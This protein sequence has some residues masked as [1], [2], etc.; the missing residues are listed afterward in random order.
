DHTVVNSPSNESVKTASVEKDDDV[1]ADQGQ[2]ND[3]DI[4]NVDDLVSE[5][6]SVEKTPTPTIAKRLRSQSG[7][8]VASVVT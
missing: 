8:A 4:V 5:E 2:N 7:K 6:R 1:P 3:D